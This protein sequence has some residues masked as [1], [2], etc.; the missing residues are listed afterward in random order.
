M[1]TEDVRLRRSG[2]AT[3]QPWLTLLARLGLAGVLGWAGIAKLAAP[4]LAVQAVAAYE[5]LPESLTTFVGYALPALEIALALLLVAGL[6][7]RF[8]AIASGLLMVVFIAGIASAWARGLNIDC[9]CFGGG[10]SIA[11]SATR[12]PEEIL[13][14]I[15]FLALAVFIAIWPRGRLA[16]DSV[17]GLYG[18]QRADDADDPDGAGDAEDAD[19]TARIV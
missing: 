8:V 2:W 16:L 9:G 18:P 6:A 15:G 14:D 11:S 4:A 19:G 3:V 12:Y 5:I 17:F 13:R 7:T 10:G 1:V